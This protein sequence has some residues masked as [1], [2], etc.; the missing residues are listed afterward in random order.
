MTRYI[1]DTNIISELA[2]KIP[3]PDVI[4]FMASASHCLVSII[5]FHELT[6]GLNA[7]PEAQKHHLTIF[8][9]Q[10]RERFG[11]TALAIDLPIAETAGRL[12]GF[13]KSQGRVLAVADSLI[14]ATALLKDKTPVT[15]NIRDFEGLDIPLINPFIVH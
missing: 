11:A 2:R 9:A 7:A 1:L 12:R 10:I 6:Y 5:V 15:R 13:I 8:L 3:N 4:N 14:A